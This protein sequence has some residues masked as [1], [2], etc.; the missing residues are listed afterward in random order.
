MKMND[1][2]YKVLKWITLIVIPACTTFYCTLD[3]I[4]GWGAGEIVAKVSAA[5]CT[6][7]GAIIG[8]STASYYQDKTEE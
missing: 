3:S 2:V 1:K 6:F 8:I 5:L 7:I 4:F